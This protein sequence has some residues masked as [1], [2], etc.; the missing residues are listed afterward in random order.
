RLLAMLLLPALGCHTPRATMPGLVE[1][2][3]AAVAP[4]RPTL[5]FAACSAE[6]TDGT[7]DLPALW[8]LALAHN[9]SLR[10]AAADVEAARGQQVQAGKY[11][12]PH[13]LYAQDV[14]G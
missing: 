14:I 5:G 11:P 1:A 8:K 12:N 7:L 9:P 13:F 10:E 3:V 6:A 4:Q 2:Q